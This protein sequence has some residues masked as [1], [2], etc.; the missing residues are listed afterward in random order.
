MFCIKITCIQIWNDIW[1]C[2][3]WQDNHFWGWTVP[4]ILIQLQLL[5]SVRTVSWTKRLHWFLRG[6]H[7]HKTRHITEHFHTLIWLHFIWHAIWGTP[8]HIFISLCLWF[9]VS[10]FL[11]L[12]LS[13]TKTH[14]H[15]PNLLP[16][17]SAS[18]QPLYKRSLFKGSV[19]GRIGPGSLPEAYQW[20]QSTLMLLLY[21]EIST[22][23]IEGKVETK[24][25]TRRETVKFR[26]TGRRWR[27]V[28]WALHKL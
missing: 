25:E 18:P 7:A 15:T 5:V 9:F 22:N 6:C 26:K 12:S 20:R 16:V 21:A 19:S 17:L 1:A 13:S 4:L 24:R 28:W 8:S 11:S 2:N 27:K 14:R 23:R 3:W 10:A